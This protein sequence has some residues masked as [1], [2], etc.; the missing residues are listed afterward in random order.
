MHITST[1]SW[2]LG[3]VALT[4][5]IACSP[6]VEL[7]PTNAKAAP[8]QAEAVK[9]PPGSVAVPPPSASE[10][11]YSGVWAATTA[12]CTETTKT[13][14]LS[15]DAL[16]LTPQS[17]NCAVK[18]LAEE[19]PTG[20]SAIYRITAVCISDPPTGA[21][22][23]GQDTIT[24]SAGASDTVMEMQVNTGAPMTLERCPTIPAP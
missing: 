20:R 1:Q 22:P 6:P 23:S 24:L 11:G 2:A 15:G 12:D 18:S 17:R 5:L 19:H 16:N 7:P 8:A 14:L 13:Y 10:P 9:V 3:A 21:P 4:V